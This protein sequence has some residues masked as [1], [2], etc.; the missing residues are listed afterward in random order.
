LFGGKP[1]FLVI[2]KIDV[3]RLDDL[4]PENRALVD[5]I[6]ADGSVKHVQMSCHSEEGVMDLKNQACDALLAHRV[7]NKLN[8]TKINS[9]INRI[10]VAMPKARDS[11]V[12]EAF[13]PDAVKARRPY[14]KTDPMRPRLEKDIEA[15]EG[16]AGV[17]NLDMRSTFS[18]ILLST[19]NSSIC[20]E[21]RACQP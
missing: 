5:E 7:E 6:I 21:L 14:D 12:R 11:V 13:I 10:H 4:T 9:V 3:T 20:R 19:R 1:T 18:T 16:G 17:Y 2:N 8:G 15:L